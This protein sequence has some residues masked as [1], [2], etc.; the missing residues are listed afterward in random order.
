MAYNLSL[1]NGS[2]LQPLTQTVN[3]QLMFGWYGVG[4]LITIFV[5]MTMS[6]MNFTNDNKKS[7]GMASFLTAV[8][9]ILM[10]SIYLLTDGQVLITWLIAAIIMMVTFFNE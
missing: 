3:E 4:L 6:F 1:I 5:I 2:G 9:S 8:L 7:L 10:R